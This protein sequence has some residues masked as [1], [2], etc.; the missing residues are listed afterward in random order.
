MGGRDALLVVL[1]MVCEFAA[2]AGHRFVVARERP[3]PSPVAA[4]PLKFQV[5]FKGYPMPGA[6]KRLEPS[7]TRVTTVKL[8]L[9][10]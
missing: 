5:Y 1:R 3:Y 10:D 8:E 9:T 6:Q 7:H 4:D 2:I